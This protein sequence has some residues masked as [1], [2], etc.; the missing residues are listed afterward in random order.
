M[1]ISL[2]LLALL[3]LQACA[4]TPIERA[5]NAYFVSSRAYQACVPEYADRL[6]KC[7]TYRRQMIGD[8]ERLSVVSGGRW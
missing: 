1:R 2:L 5:R 6:W 7:E 8:A 4:A 3:S